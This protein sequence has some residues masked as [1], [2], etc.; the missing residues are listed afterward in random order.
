MSPTHTG[1]HTHT[2]WILLVL[3][4]V[5]VV[6]ETISKAGIQLGIGLHIHVTWQDHRCFTNLLYFQVLQMQSIGPFET[7]QQKWLVAIWTSE[8]N[9]SPNGQGAQSHGTIEPGHGVQIFLSRQG[10]GDPGGSPPFGPSLQ[11]KAMS[12]FEGWGVTSKER[13]CSHGL[14]RTL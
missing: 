11:A 8:E 12:I 2:R 6:A 7:A 1:T 10:S 4:G 5:I 3:E 9:H 14:R 13:R